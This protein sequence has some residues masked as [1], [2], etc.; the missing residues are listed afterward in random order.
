MIARMCLGSQRKKGDGRRVWCYIYYHP[1]LDH[2]SASFSPLFFRR[3]FSFPIRTL[4]MLFFWQ[5]SHNSPISS[6]VI[7]KVMV[8]FF[9]LSLSQNI[10]HVSLGFID[11]WLFN[12]LCLL[13]ALLCA[14]ICALHFNCNS[15]ILSYYLFFVIL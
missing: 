3:A 15:A 4:S 10:F 9:S 11:V 14:D 1:C 2:L 13:G 8:D 7:C 6:R 12:Y 5:S